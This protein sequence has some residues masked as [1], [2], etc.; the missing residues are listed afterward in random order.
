MFK[1]TQKWI[2][3]GIDIKK[4]KSVKV[5]YD[6]PHRVYHTWNHI[7]DMLLLLDTIPDITND[8][9]VALQVAV[10][11]HD[12][13]YIIGATD[14]ELLSAELFKSNHGTDTLEKR[15]IYDAILST[16]DHVVTSEL[17]SYLID[18][19]LYDLRYPV[20]EKLITNTHNLFKEAIGTSDNWDAFLDASLFF[21]HDYKAR[22][23][24]GYDKLVAIVKSIPAPHS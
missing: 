16:K 18:L 10:V 7:N 12:A 13:V 20:R 15:M 3:N 6:E 21:L 14:N 5:C 1:L 22:I 17:S 11:Y 19:D 2:A 4:L 8:M 24:D 23:G 9:K